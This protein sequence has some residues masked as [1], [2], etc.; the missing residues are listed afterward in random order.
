MNR[1]SRPYLWAPLDRYGTGRLSAASGASR[2]SVERWRH[3][4][5]VS[6]RDAD[7]VAVGLGL[8]PAM[9]WPEW[10]TDAQQ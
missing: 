4:G 5:A 8:H 7:R 10:G 6:E 1:S 3:R 2:K 9:L